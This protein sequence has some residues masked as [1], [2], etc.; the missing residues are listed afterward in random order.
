MIGFAANRAVLL[1]QSAGDFSKDNIRVS[2][3]VCGLGFYA[4]QGSTTTCFS[5]QPG[6]DARV[7]CW[8]CSLPL[9]L[10]QGLVLFSCL[11]GKYFDIAGQ[12]VTRCFGE[13]PRMSHCLIAGCGCVSADCAAGTASSGTGSTVCTNCIAGKFST[14]GVRAESVL[15][16]T[17]RPHSWCLPASQS[18]SCSLCPVGS[19]SNAVGAGA[20]PF[21]PAGSFSNAP[22]ASICSLCS[23]GQFQDATNKTVCKTCSPGSAARFP[24][25]SFC[26]PCALVRDR[27]LL[28][29]LAD[30]S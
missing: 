5:C 19:A 22:G 2:Y 18:V 9:W 8:S 24:G 25:L 13:S 23:V 12:D 7:F 28:A 10:A 1:V 27:D 17:W 30:H 6:M 3:A 4:A 11:P 29:L 26:T 21:C 15:D 16:S 20:C 14:P